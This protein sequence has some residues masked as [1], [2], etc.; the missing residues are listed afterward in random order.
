M[1]I[2]LFSA[3]FGGV[4]TGIGV[5]IGAL[6]AARLRPPTYPGY[7]L[8]GDGTAASPLAVT[9]VRKPTKREPRKQAEHRQRQA[10]P[11]IAPEAPPK[12]DYFN[13]PATRALAID[14]NRTLVASGFGKAEAAAAVADCAGSERSTLDSWLRAALKRLNRAGQT[15]GVVTS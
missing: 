9:P 1:N 7:E 3:L 6:V 4:L 2:D 5:Y 15:T 13:S 11:V 12:S 10:I 14:V 8:T